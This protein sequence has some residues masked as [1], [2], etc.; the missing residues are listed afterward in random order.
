MS[1]DF[2]S[3]IEG[4]RS[5]FHEIPPRLLFI[6][7][8]E[9]HTKSVIMDSLKANFLV[10]KCFHGKTKEK[11]LEKNT[12]SLKIQESALI[13][14]FLCSFCSSSSKKIPIKAT[15]VIESSRDKN[16]VPPTYFYK[17]NCFKRCKQMSLE[18]TLM[19]LLYSCRSCVEFSFDLLFLVLNGL[20]LRRKLT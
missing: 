3:Q 1:C 14:V 19:A 13:T 6:E 2:I 5:R 18:V 12:S 9:R 11:R 10:F 15:Q 17:E 4:L 20:I 16:E 8:L 7:S